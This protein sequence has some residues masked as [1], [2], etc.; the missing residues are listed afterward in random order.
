MA[1]VLTKAA[2]PPNDVP[3]NLPP[4]SRRADDPR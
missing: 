3:R 1:L 2:K 4:Q